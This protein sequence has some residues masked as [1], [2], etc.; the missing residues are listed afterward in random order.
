MRDVPPRR[1]R[2][3]LMVGAAAQFAGFA[4]AQQPVEDR[5][6][7]ME[8]C[9][10]RAF[11]GIATG[12]VKQDD[13]SVAT[14]KIEFAV[15][16][17]W[18]DAAQLF[19]EGDSG[20]V[21]RTYAHLTAESG[22]YFEFSSNRCV[23]GRGLDRVAMGAAEPWIS[24]RGWLRSVRFAQ[25]QGQ[26]IDILSDRIIIVDPRQRVE[27]E[28]DERMRVTAATVLGADGA[29]L[30]RDEYSEWQPL[31]EGTAH[32]RR[33]VDLRYREGGRA[34][35]IHITLSDMVVVDDS[36]P[37]TPRTLPA[38]AIYL[39]ELRGEMRQAGKIIGPWPPPAAGAAGTAL[40]S[41]L[42]SRTVTIAAGIGLLLLAGLIFQFKRRAA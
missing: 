17:E 23:L 16:P 7:A 21:P 15:G 40:G 11:K 26:K 37:P 25:R 19:K 4:C 9:I 36:A 39:D 1:F 14:W 28:H 10:S 30:A 6:A 33:V 12:D 41:W 18:Y 34:D 27:I 13:R 31:G 24:V 42:S 2:L 5:L 38:D 3:M 8:M 29:R 35:E 20:W 32:P 22:Q